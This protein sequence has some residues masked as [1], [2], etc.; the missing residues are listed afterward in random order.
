MVIIA[1]NALITP[2]TAKETCPLC[3]KSHRIV[4]FTFQPGSVIVQQIL[5]LL[6]DI[7]DCACT[8]CQDTLPCLLLPAP[9][10]TLMGSGFIGSALLDSFAAFFQFPGDRTAKE[11]SR[12]RTIFEW[13]FFFFFPE[14]CFFMLIT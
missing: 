3:A 13:C 8:A 4:T 6:P 10:T 12:A 11:F 14:P 7:E 5:F 2:L 9:M 1:I